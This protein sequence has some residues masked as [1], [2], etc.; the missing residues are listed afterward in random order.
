MNKARHMRLVICLT[1]RLLSASLLGASALTLPAN[2]THFA[3]LPKVT[4]PR[5]YVFDCGT[6]VHNKPEDYN[7]TRDEVKDSNM[8]VTCYLVAHPRA[9]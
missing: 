5:L 2:A 7:L 1:I 8:G 4:S 3:P 9:C 6:L